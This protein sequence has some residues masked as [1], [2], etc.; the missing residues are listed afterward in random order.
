MSKPCCKPSHKSPT[1]SSA[2]VMGA[3]MRLDLFVFSGSVLTLMAK[4][5]ICEMA[6]EVVVLDW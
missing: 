2:L 4:T 1:L 5:G 6:C 3:S